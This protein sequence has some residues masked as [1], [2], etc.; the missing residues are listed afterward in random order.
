VDR[1]RREDGTYDAERQGKGPALHELASDPR[2]LR[3]GRGIDVAKDLDQIALGAIRP[4]HERE[5]ADEQREKWDERKEDL[6]RDGTGEE[7][8]LVRGEALDDGS[9]AR[10]GAG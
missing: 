6:V 7:W 8:T 1:H 9:A 2:F 4:V 3:G 10:N 5:D